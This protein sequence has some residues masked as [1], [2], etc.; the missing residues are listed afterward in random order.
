VLIGVRSALAKFRPPGSGV[1]RFGCSLSTGIVGV[2]QVLVFEPAAADFKGGTRSIDLLL[3][4]DGCE[5]E[6]VCW[7]IRTE[8]GE[9]WEKRK[10]REKRSTGREVLSWCFSRVNVSSK[11]E[12]HLNRHGALD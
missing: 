6:F 8:M 2:N 1:L 11:G 3:S 9:Y 10:R 7:S 12:L 5:Y 4:G